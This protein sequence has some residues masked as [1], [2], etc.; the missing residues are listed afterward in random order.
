[1]GFK[2]RVTESKFTLLDPR[3]LY[4]ARL[5]KVEEDEMEWRGQPQPKF[6]FFFTILDPPEF[7]GREVDG[8][9][10]QPANGELNERHTLYK[11]LTALEG[12]VPPTLGSEI[13]FP[14]QFIGRI[15]QVQVVNKEKQYEGQSEKMT[16][17]NVKT[18]AVCP[19]PSEF[20]GRGVKRD[21]AGNPAGGG[22]GSASDAGSESPS[23]S[24]PD[25]SEANTDQ[26]APQEPPK[27]AG[28]ADGGETS[29]TVEVDG[30]EE[31]IPF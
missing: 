14:E 30:V 11:W 7:E 27:D 16:F 13:D 20:E 26:P 9:V 24:A 28:G 22:S 19:N 10:N 23:P 31:E 6:K 18:L 29:G 1:M 2:L 15:V 25:A 17:Q 8:M 21:A 4:P 12:G 5:D 3:A